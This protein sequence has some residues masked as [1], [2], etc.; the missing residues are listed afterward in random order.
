MTPVTPPFPFFRAATTTTAVAMGTLVIVAA[1]CAVLGQT[2]VLPLAVI[3]G[4]LCL[5][6]AAAALVPVGLFSG[7]RP[8]GL[9][10]GF[11]V[12][13]MARILLGVG[14]IGGIVYL[15]SFGLRPT[16]CWVG[17]WY[18]LLLGVNVW[19]LLKHVRQLEPLEPD[20]DVLETTQ[21]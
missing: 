16:A 9:M 2:H 18:M 11:M 15:A 14:I 4:L 19:L 1:G 20:Q 13:E 10:Q 12:G 6:A 3:S 21:S 17:G 7:R 8:E 5:A